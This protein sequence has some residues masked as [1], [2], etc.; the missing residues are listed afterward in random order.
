[1]VGE[2]L[3]FNLDFKTKFEFE[4]SVDAGSDIA[5]E[6]KNKEYGLFKVELKKWV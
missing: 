3:D 6:W 1:M 2:N 5:F 4:R